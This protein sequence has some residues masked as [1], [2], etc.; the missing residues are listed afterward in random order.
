MKVLLKQDG[1]GVSG[2]SPLVMHN[3]ILADPLNATV[4]EIA[5]YTKK[6]NK[7]EADHLEIARLEFGGG[8]YTNGNGPCLPAFNILRC[9]QDGAKRLK[10]GPD[11]LRGV[12]PISDHADVVYDGPRDTDELWKDGGFA[13]RKTVGIQ[14]SRT[15]RTRPIFRDWE[16]ELPVEVDAS[17]WDLDTLAE[18]WRL[19]G[20]FCGQGEMRPVYGRFAGTLQVVA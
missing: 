6:R 5:T 14:R 1:H 10:R 15:M 7:T 12:Y 8:L 11:V 19:A 3:E 16:T 20:M 13:L 4:R 2:G 17:I 9:L 18:V